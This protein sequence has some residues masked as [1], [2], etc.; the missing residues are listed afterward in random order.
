MTA[1]PDPS[2]RLTSA[3][4]EPPQWTVVIDDCGVTWVRYDGIYGYD[5]ARNWVQVDHL[6]GDPESWTK[7]AGNYGPVRRVSALA[8]LMRILS[9]DTGES[10]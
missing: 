10:E 5:G 7:I 1:V 9:A 2:V 4:P 8:P 3:D 6:D